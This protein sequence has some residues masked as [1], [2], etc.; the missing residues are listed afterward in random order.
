MRTLVAMLLAV[1]MLV[2]GRADAQLDRSIVPGPGPAPATAFPE[3][4]VITTAN[5]MRVIIV[6]NHELPTVALRLLVDRPPVAEKDMVGIIDV[7]GMLM[8]NGTTTR[9]K[10]QLDEAVDAIDGSLGAGGTAVYAS[11]LARHTEKL[12]EL[13]ADVT[14]HPS[15]AESELQKIIMQTKSGLKARKSEPDEIVDVLRS[16]VL[17]GDKHPY[18]EV[19]TEASVGKITRAACQKV[20]KTWFVPNAVIL[21]VVGDVQKDQVLDLV[22][23]HFGSWKKGTLPKQS[24]PA[25]PPLEKR[26][27][28]LV[29]R[30]GSVQSALRVGQTLDLPRTSP[31]VM[32]VT[33]MNKVLGGG[34]ARLFTNL[35][36]K[37]SYTYGAYSS[38]SPDELVGAFTVQTS[39]RN[40]VTDSALTE[41]FF[42]LNR[43]RDEVVDAKEL[44]RAKNSLSGNFV[45]SLEKPETIARYAIDIE[46]YH[47]PRDHY[48]TYLQRVAAV[49]PQDVQRA[50]QKYLT[51]GKMVVA[52]VGSGKDV[53][54]KLAA[55]GDVRMFDEDGNPVTEKASA[56][57]TMTAAQIFTKFVERTG[58]AAKY[59]A[60]KDRT[61]EVSGKIQG[62][63]MKIRTIQR[64][65]S[66]LYQEVAMMGMLQKQVF[67][68][69][70]GWTSSPMGSKDLSGEDLE[71]VQKDAPIESYGALAALGVK[72]EVTGRKDVKG[73]DCYE[74]TLTTKSGSVSRHYFDAKEFLK[75]R[76]VSVKTTPR[77][78]VEQITDM[79]DYKPFGGVLIP[80]KNE[81]T[82]MGTTF[83]L[84]VD[85]VTVNTGVADSL[86]VKPAGK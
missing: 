72:A 36:E 52:V 55:F 39:V 14:L 40:A 26:S 44:E 82:V 25:V 46:R 7:T 31:D 83:T 12:F 71:D 17:Y 19:E 10:D 67:N 29:D 50:A 73:V 27:V 6:P 23:K 37:H 48:R 16:R 43:M 41:I 35:R 77:G 32:A 49:T 63:D 85:K 8:R 22:K 21:A 33:V 11:G 65:P 24:Y 57:I 84:T 56:P 59:A 79:S 9:T 47:L 34:V 81:Q 69:T 13:L 5:G 1:L 78:P 61:I 60:I 42:E 74:V 75:V 51:P 38:V 64:A 45:Q 28:A 76:E 3:Y 53:K 4:D 86:F 68:G 80:T 30:S 70:A 15:F 20:Y 58:G 18:G 54:A 62:M 66:A 2:A